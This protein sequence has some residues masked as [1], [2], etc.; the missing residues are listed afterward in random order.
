MT[1]STKTTTKATPKTPELKVQLLVSDMKAPTRG[2][3]KAHC[4]DLYLPTSLY[5]NGVARGYTQIVPLC[6][7][8]DIPSGYTVKI[9]LRSSVGRDFPFSLANTVGIID[10]DFTGEVKVFLRNHSNKS[11]MF[12]KDTR[13]FQMELVKREEVNLKIVSEITKATDRGDESG[14]TGK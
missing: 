4:Y 2:T 12:D 10:E 5:V 1:T 8:L 13:L 14:S 3:S 11:Y 9:H 7:R 6:I